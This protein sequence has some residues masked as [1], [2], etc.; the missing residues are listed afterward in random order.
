M[1]RVTYR[2]DGKVF[3]LSSLNLNLRLGGE[4]WDVP[5]WSGTLEMLEKLRSSNPDV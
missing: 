1:K 3:S 4:P 2:V 5:G